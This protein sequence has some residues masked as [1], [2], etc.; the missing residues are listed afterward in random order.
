MNASTALQNAMASVNTALKAALMPESSRV[1][2]GKRSEFSSAWVLVGSELTTG[3]FIEADDNRSESVLFRY[4]NSGD[5]RDTWAQ[6]T[7]VFYGTGSSLEVYEFDG[8][9]SIDPTGT[10]PF[11]SGRMVRVPNERYTVV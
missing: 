3:V 6:A 4:A 2:L 9:D 1:F 11:W 5:F 7:H 8:K 10:S